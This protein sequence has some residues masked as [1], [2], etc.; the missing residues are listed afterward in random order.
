MSA[1][2]ST[3]Q[4]PF[5]ELMMRGFAWA[6]GQ[7]VGGLMV[8]LITLV[9]LSRLL[10]PSEFGIVAMIV[11]LLG[12]L[13]M[14]VELGVG[15]A[16]IQRPSITSRHIGS[17]LW[18]S[19]SLAIAFMVVLQLLAHP[20][21][22]W[23]GIGDQVTA[24]RVLT[25]MLLL[26]PL[27]TILWALTRRDLRMRE[28]ATADLIGTA[29]GY[30]LVSITLALLGFGLWALVS[31]HIA[32]LGL[33]LLILVYYRRRKLSLRFGIQETRDVLSFGAYFSI[34]RIAN[35]TAQRFDR[36]LIGALLGAEAAGYYQRALNM[37][38]LVAPFVSGPLENVMFPLLSRI[39]D[40]TAR[41]RRSYR[42][43]TAVAAMVTMPV[44]VLLCIS[45]PVLVP[46]VLG[47]QWHGVVLPAQIMSGFLFFRTNDSITA[48]L[49]RATGRVKARAALQVLYAVLSLGSI[50]ALQDFRLEGIAAGL[51]CVTILNFTLMSFL[52][53]RVTSMTMA[54][55]FAPLIPAALIALCLAL[56]AAGSYLLLGDA[57]FTLP[58]MSLHL[59]VSGLAYL[60][61]AL[62]LPRSLLPDEV[63]SLRSA[64]LEKAAQ[65]VGM[66]KLVKPELNA[67]QG[68]GQST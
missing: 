9:V 4:P 1:N 6:F 27:V 14:V 30:S 16:L 18:L 35:F 45:A 64:V 37:L 68:V 31:A 10:T 3:R 19:M 50:W 61:L 46:L 41:L 43:S 34:G 15:P 36:V 39:Q 20:L 59:V 21:G 2:P 13:T 47:S 58:W 7:S 60:G 38:Q 52:V 28:A 12:G 51:L 56:L 25:A 5:R 32:Q 44:S 24:L 63:A 57:L 54:D 17:A 11:S 62:F 55:N 42:A 8:Q 33:T 67:A 40:D 65:G 66:G 23:V 26:Q 22:V 53:R 29:L 48:T 49:M